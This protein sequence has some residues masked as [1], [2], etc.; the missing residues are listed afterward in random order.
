[1]SLSELCSVVYVWLLDE[2]HRQYDLAYLA[3]SIQAAQGA[4]VEQPP[5]WFEVRQSFDEK[6][7]ESLD[8]TEEDSDEHILKQAL[9]LES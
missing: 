1:L 7:S 3:T 8:V 6:L 2:L 4:E 9:G 5:T